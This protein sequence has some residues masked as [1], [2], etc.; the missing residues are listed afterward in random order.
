MGLNYKNVAGSAY[1]VSEITGS[2]RKNESV[3]T[4]IGD[5]WYLY[6]IADL[7]NEGKVS[8]TEFVN[9]VDAHQSSTE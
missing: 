3:Q 5:N 9:F 1:V 4:N 6:V 7:A 8:D 2:R